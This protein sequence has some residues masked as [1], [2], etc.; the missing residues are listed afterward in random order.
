MNINNKS[1]LD[2]LKQFLDDIRTMKIQKDPLYFKSFMAVHSPRRIIE[3]LSK[4]FIKGEGHRSRRFFGS[5]ILRNIFHV[6]NL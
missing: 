6:K 1:K 3:K 5:K 4:S 2:L